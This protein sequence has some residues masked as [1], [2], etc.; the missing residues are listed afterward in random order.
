MTDDELHAKFIGLA[1]PVLKN[2][3]K[4]KNGLHMLRELEKARDIRN[5][6]HLVT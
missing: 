4:T 5:L 2:E 3:D 1:L 6:M